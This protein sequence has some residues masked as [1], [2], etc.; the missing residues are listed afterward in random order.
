MLLFGQTVN[1]LPDGER[2]SK[3]NPLVCHRGVEFPFSVDASTAYDVDANDY[4]FDKIKW[5]V[6]GDGVFMP[7]ETL[8]SKEEILGESSKSSVKV[9]WPVSSTGSGHTEVTL[10][11]T[12]T[13]RDSGGEEHCNSVTSRIHIKLNTKPTITATASVVLVKC[14]NEGENWKPYSE[15]FDFSSVP[16]NDADGD[17]LEMSYRIEDAGG[18]LVETV[19]DLSSAPTKSYPVGSYSVILVVKDPFCTVES[20]IYTMVIHKTPSPSEIYI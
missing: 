9:K 11:V 7:D 1:E 13:S 14:S 3:S 12:Q 17:A 8:S 19:T 18:N 16:V 20:V 2:G 6:S 10:D 4:K 5:E 15:T